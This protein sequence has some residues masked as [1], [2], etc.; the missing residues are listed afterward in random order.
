VIF[1]GI[2]TSCNAPLCRD[3]IYRDSRFTSKF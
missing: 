1:H 2:G 3:G